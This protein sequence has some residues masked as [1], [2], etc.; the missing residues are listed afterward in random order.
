L[1]A[2]EG[3]GRAPAACA[4][5][6]DEKLRLVAAAGVKGRAFYGEASRCG[7]GFTPRDG[8]RADIPL[9]GSAARML[10][11]CFTNWA[12][13]PTLAAQFFLIAVLQRFFRTRVAA[14]W[15]RGDAGLFVRASPTTQRRLHAEP[16]QRG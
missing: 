3:R 7:L 5:F 2:A 15:F 4:P 14:L 11:G 12:L 10:S 9:M 16:C 13:S 1:A 6:P 8:S